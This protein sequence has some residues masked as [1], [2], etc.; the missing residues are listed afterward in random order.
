MTYLPKSTGPQG[1]QLPS[2]T[3]ATCDKKSDLSCNKSISSLDNTLDKQLA[4]F[5]VVNEDGTRFNEDKD[6]DE[7][8]GAV[9]CER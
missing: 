6:K 3:K 4:D 9:F 8:A 5:K 2:I 7:D 1:K